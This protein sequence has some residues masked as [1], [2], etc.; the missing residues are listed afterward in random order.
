MPRDDGRAETT[1][2]L[3]WAMRV[4]RLEAEVAGLRRAMASRGAIEQAKGV[5]A[6]RMGCSPEAAFAHLST[7][8]QRSNVRLSDVAA[9]L[10]A[11]MSEP[12]DPAGA[13]PSAED[14]AEDEL[15]A[16]APDDTALSLDF[17]PVYRD[18]ATQAPACRD[19]TD[20]AELMLGC[21]LGPDVVAVH[22]IGNGANVRGTATAA[23]SD[24]PRQARAGGATG[25]ARA[26]ARSRAPAAARGHQQ[27][28]SPESEPTAT[29]PG[30]GTAAAISGA[31]AEALSSAAAEAMATGGP[32][33][34]GDGAA[35]GRVAAVPLHGVDGAF[36]AISLGWY[37]DAQSGTEPFTTRERR[38]LGALAPVAQRTAARLWGPPSHPMSSILDVGYDPG[39]LLQPVRDDDGRVVDFVIEY[40][41]AD[42]PDMAGLARGEQIGRRLLDTYPHLGKSG[43]FDAYR[44][45]LETGEPWARGAQQETV[46]LDGAPTVVTVRRRA[47]RYGGGLLVT[48]HRD[49]DRVRRERQLQRMEALGH[50]GWADW[51]LAGRQSYWSPG[52]FRIF[53][54]EPARGPIAF[55]SL[56]DAVGD[57]EQDSVTAMVNAVNR[58]QAAGAEFRLA[59][60]DGERHVRII[61]EPVPASDGR[62]IGALAVAQDLTET[63]TADERMLRVE[64][65]LAEQRLNLA[66]QRDVTRELRHVLYPALICDVQ[67]DSVHIA[68]RH[69][70]PDDDRYLR[71]DFCDATLLDDGHILFA[72]GDSFGSGVR[73]G[74]VLARL[75]Y[76]ARA[77][78]NAGVPPAALLGILNADF[79]RDDV[80]PLASMVVGRYC[81]V[82]R[83]VRWAQAG[84]LPPVRLL[85][86]GTRMLDRPDGPALGLLE[87]ANF[88]QSRTPVRDGDMIVW[89]TDGMVFDRAHPDS[90]PWPQLRRSLAAAGRAAGLDGVLSLC[91]ATDMND[92]ACMLVLAALPTARRAGATCRS[93]G[94]GRGYEPSSAG[95]ASAAS[96]ES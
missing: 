65:R 67:T 1:A 10:L 16:D 71:G 59:D 43:V 14:D 38:H 61:A 72:V 21:G 3:D 39:F 63:R 8:S 45:V 82:D 18:V 78:G 26:R 2:D 47:I 11:S 70:A 89:M 40:A 57:A 9:S 92:E 84:H 51:D 95:A 62:V 30:R 13:A 81:P 12:T 23:R 58:G 25:A 37:A 15:P 5:L 91:R 54:R 94:C 20:L 77:L 56:A 83:V 35:F 46:V 41:S 4:Q 86:H 96:V 53:D 88:A 69:A 50:F 49:D 87:S 34:R 33:W 80:P 17:A 31:V 66:A 73:A 52:M 48:W 68:G 19:L 36:G 93:V 79:H 27:A 75:L 29:E 28:R 60:D 76:P 7:L 90:D 22:E 44:Q 32:V 74:E 6:E 42:V 55:A 85:G 64:A 24:P